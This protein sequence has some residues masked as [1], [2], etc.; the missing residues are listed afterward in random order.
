MAKSPPPR[1]RFQQAAAPPSPARLWGK[2]ELLI[3]RMSQEGR[4]IASRQGKVVFVSGALPGETVLAQCT[5]VRRDYDEAQMLGLVDGTCPAPERSEPACPIYRDCGGCTLQH[6]SLQA[7]QAHKQANLLALLRPLAPGLALDPP[8]N[9][10]PS[11]YRH[12]LRLLVQ[13]NPDQSCLLGMRRRGSHEA[14]AV[15]H[16][17]VANTFVN[18][19]LETLPAM[20]AAAPGLQ[21]LREIEVDSDSRG[22]LGLCC[23]FAAN[24]GDRGLALLRDALLTGPVVAL[25]V[26][27]VA[28]RKPRPGQD[29]DD[30]GEGVAEWQELYAE[31]ELR[32]SLDCPGENADSPA[33]VEEMAYLPGDFTQTNWEVNSA[34]VS[35]ALAWLRP[36]GDER[37]LDLFSGIGNFALPLARR[38][39]AVDALEGDASMTARLDEN[40]ARN[41]I[42]NI[43][44]RTVNLMAAAPVLPRADIAIIDPPRAGAKAVCE[45]LPRTGVKRLVY[46]S[47]HPATL[48]RDARGL[49][50]AGFKLLRAAAVDM[51]PHTGHS[52]AIALFERVS[53]R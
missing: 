3:D 17:L 52:E 8:I 22:Q 33:Q 51:F 29:W 2:D 18:Q 12:R 49:Q 15:R 31:G 43:R 32:L 34:L 7:Q 26:R 38:A 36:R 27:L 30:A 47:C 25:R 13:R 9:S 28:P 4:G 16:C 14:V 24:P 6:W 5:A 19:L 53:K 23:Y 21:G 40:A 37:A 10:A 1:K 41:G 48:A 42:S 39:A 45:A 11:A 46:V 44:A 50:A 35:R 20:L